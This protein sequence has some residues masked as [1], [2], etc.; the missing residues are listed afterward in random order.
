MA[1]RSGVDFTIESVVRGYHIYQS[2]WT[3]NVGDEFVLQT[4][5]QN[6]HYRYAVAVVASGNVVGHVPKEISKTMFFFLRSNGVVPGAV[7]GRRQ[8]SLVEG[9]GLEIPCIYKF[10][11]DSKKL[12]ILKKLLSRPKAHA[13]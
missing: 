2:V 4:Q 9:K 7:T 11:S 3:P 6:R 12:K 5:E 10:Y 13:L 8:R 1:T